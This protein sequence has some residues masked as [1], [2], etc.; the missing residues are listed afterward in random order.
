MEN[1][2]WYVGPV[3]GL[4]VSDACIH[5]TQARSEKMVEKAVEICNTHLSED[6]RMKLQDLVVCEKGEE[7]AQ[8]KKDVLR[9]ALPEIVNHVSDSNV[10]VAANISE[11]I[12]EHTLQ[13]LEKI[14]HK[15]VS[16]LILILRLNQFSHF[17]W[18]S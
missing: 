13:S 5:C 2:L 6:T 1:T 11:L 12:V 7:F 16:G 17:P 18:N 3:G 14:N 8:A 15:L 10:D 4:M 9:H